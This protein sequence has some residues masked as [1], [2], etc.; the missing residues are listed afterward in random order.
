MTPTD[1]ATITRVMGPVVRE[2]TAKAV[3]DA[4]SPLLVKIA[5]LETQL[6]KDAARIEGYT[7][8]LQRDLTALDGRV[9]VVESCAAVLPQTPPEPVAGPVGLSGQKGD[10]GP[11]IASLVVSAEGRLLVHLTDGRSLDAGPVPRGQTGDI[12]ERGDVGPVGPSGPEGERG[13]RGDKGEHGIV[14]SLGPQGERGLPGAQ[15]ERGLIGEKGE[16]GVDGKD[17][18]AGLN[19]KDGAPGLHGKDGA[20]GLDGKDGAPGE[21]GPQGEKG[22]DGLSGRDG[23]DGTPGHPG[24]TGEKG[25]DGRHG[26]DG[27]NGKDGLN[28][29]GFDDFDLTLDETRGWILRLSQGERVKEWELGIP[30]DAK[31]YQAGLVYPKGAGVTWDGNYWIALKQTSE[32]PGEGSPAWRLAVRRGKQGREGKQGKDGSAG[33]DLTSI[34]PSTGR[35]W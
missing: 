15:G 5:A 34:D 33:R 2:Y 30:F 31:V 13:E 25:L 32:Q 3:A 18:A 19:G 7:S 28:G 23:R 35:K 10:A 11:G 8:F 22:I 27:L 16:S 24:A 14:G 29:L 17:G 21:L 9:A 26:V 1:I 4:T 20:V 6:D 12:G